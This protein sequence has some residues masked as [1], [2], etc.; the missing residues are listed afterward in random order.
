MEI[1]FYKKQIHWLDSTV[2]GV[3]PN[4]SF[5]HILIFL[6]SPNIPLKTMP[7]L[8]SLCLLLGLNYTHCGS[9]VCIPRHE[10]VCLS[11]SCSFL[12]QPPLRDY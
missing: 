3:G 12:P 8:T 5:V 1:N 2:A 4:I 7:R 10:S 11:Y 6:F 9:V